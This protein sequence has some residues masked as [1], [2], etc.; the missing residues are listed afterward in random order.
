MQMDLTYDTIIVGA[1]SSGAALASRLSED[2]ARSVLIVEAGPDYFT[3]EETPEEVRRALPRDILLTGKLLGF[4]SPHD[5][6]YTA[7]ATEEVGEMPLPRGRA[8]GGSSAVNSSIFL[9]G[10]PEDYDG[11]AAAG[12]DEWTFDRLLPYLCRLRPTPILRTTSTAMTA[13]RP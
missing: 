1:G 13:L 2:P 4:D 9:R 5:W 6:T 8:V 10:V 12:N 7:K 11:W 3:L